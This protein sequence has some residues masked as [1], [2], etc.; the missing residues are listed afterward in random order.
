M[1]SPATVR[2]ITLDGSSSYRL[3]G[4][5]TLILDANT[6][7][8]QLTVT[9]G[10]HIWTA[11]VA[12][13]TSTAIDI[14]SGAELTLEGSFAF[15]NQTVTKSGSGHLYLD[16]ELTTQSGTFQHN[17]GR[18]G[19]DG[20]INGD[21][22]LA[23]AAVAPGHDIGQLTVGGDFTMGSDSALEI[24]IGGT[25]ANQFDTLQVGQNVYLNGTLEVT[26]T[27]DYY[28]DFGQQFFCCA[29]GKH[30]QL[31]CNAGGTRCR[32]VQ[33]DLQLR[34]GCCSSRRPYPSQL[35]SSGLHPAATGMTRLNGHPRGFPTVTTTRLSSP[36]PSRRSPP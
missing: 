33:T 17:D 11:P 19:G 16:S 10:N 9:G 25:S 8:A 23:A 34:R 5:R 20:T 32:Q 21:L 4:N 36:V 28:P 12:T 30:C 13:N 15:L 35:I 18:L 2:E 1:D 22:I 14:A 27:D 29:S 3:E 7:T 26:L 24:E 6:G 31:R